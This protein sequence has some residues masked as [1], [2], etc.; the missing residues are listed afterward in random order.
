M[1][2]TLVKHELPPNGLKLNVTEGT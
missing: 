2:S 1:A